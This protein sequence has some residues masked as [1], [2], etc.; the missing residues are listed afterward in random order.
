MVRQSRVLALSGFLVGVAIGSL[1]F[2]PS[3]STGRST[4]RRPVPAQVENSQVA[5][6]NSQEKKSCAPS[7]I[8]AFGLLAAVAIVAT[9]TVVSA[10]VWTEQGPGNTP[11]DLTNSLDEQVKWKK[12]IA[13]RANKNDGRLWGP[14]PNKKYYPTQT[15]PLPGRDKTP[16]IN[17]DISPDLLDKKDYLRIAG[18]YERSECEGGCQWSQKNV[19]YPNRG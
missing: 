4:P 17:K 2:V 19:P 1:V 13:K 18:P 6:G 3:I 16:P 15:G 7:L 9:S 12:S 10:G 11:G 8:A 14:E 5:T